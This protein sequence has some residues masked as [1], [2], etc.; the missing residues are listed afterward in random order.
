MKDTG[1]LESTDLGQ[2]FF[3]D[4]AIPKPKAILLQLHGLGEH[5]G[6]YQHVASYFNQK[7][8]FFRAIDWPGHGKTEGLRG[9][10]EGID[11]LMHIV[12]YFVQKTRTEYPGI[13]LFLYGHSMGGNLGLYYTLQPDPGINGA[14]FTGPWIQLAFKPSPLLV[15]AGKVVGRFLPKFTQASNLDVSYLSRDPKVVDA[16]VNDPLVHDQISAG[17]GLAILKSADY[18]DHFAGTLTVPVLIMHGSGDK[19]TSEP[20]SRAFCERVNGPISFKSWDGFYHE[21]HNEPEKMEV[22]D[23]MNHWI[24]TKMG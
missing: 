11:Q 20:A 18:L 10:A 17:L 22:F 7:G 5:S 23:F 2:L 3:R 6:R 16:Y 15:F 9:H 4:W 1:T 24:K 13:P 19:I 12:R 14:I 21:I 8:F